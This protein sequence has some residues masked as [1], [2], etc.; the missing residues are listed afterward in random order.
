[1]QIGNKINIG[2]GGLLVQLGSV[3]SPAAPSMDLLLDLYPGAEV[4]YSFRKLSSDYT[5]YC[6]RVKRDSDD[7][8]L[9]IGF[10][11]DNIVDV[12]AIET[13]VG[14]NN[15]TFAWYDQSGNDKHLITLNTDNWPVLVESGTVVKQGECYT[16][17]FTGAESLISNEVTTPTTAAFLALLADVPD[18]PSATEYLVGKYNTDGNQRSYTLV[19]RDTG[20]MAVFQSANGTSSV[21]IQRDRDGYAFYGTQINTSSSYLYVGTGETSGSLTSFYQTSA[22][23]VIGASGA[24][25]GFFTGNI[26]ELI[27]Y[28][29]AQTATADEIKANVLEYKNTGEAGEQ[30]APPLP[31][32]TTNLTGQGFD[33][34]EIDRRLIHLA[35]LG[36]TGEDIII[37]GNSSPTGTSASARATLTSQ[38]NQIL[39]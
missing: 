27:Q 26:A 4:A 31:D 8:T 38:G 32:N 6:C 36:L 39:Y 17:K 14:S 35:T 22:N 16:G 15:A 9:D 34:A 25:A 21:Y 28:N 13:F 1:M 18:T 12:T 3:A 33:S 5:G 30:T 10:T 2:R 19:C 37:T 29:S 11:T 23:F 7:T 24:D 20:Q